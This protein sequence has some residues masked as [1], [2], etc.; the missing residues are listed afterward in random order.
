MSEVELFQKFSPRQTE[1]ETENGINPTRIHGESPQFNSTA[2]AH[3][4]TGAHTFSVDACSIL[5]AF[6][7]EQ[8]TLASSC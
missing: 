5:I 2:T 7:N 8:G 1:K 3:H 6:R 4:H